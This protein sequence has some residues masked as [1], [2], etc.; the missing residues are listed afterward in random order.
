MENEVLDYVMNT[1][2]NTNPAILEQMLDANSG[3]K[4]PE[5]TPEDNGKVL[6][7]SEGQYALV[8]GGGGGGSVELFVVTYNPDTG[9]IDASYNEIKAAV[10]SGKIVSC[11]SV[12]VTPGL[13]PG[14]PSITEEIE[15]RALQLIYKQT[16]ED[17]GEGETVSYCAAFANIELFSDDPDADMHSN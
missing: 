10:N 15:F 3:T 11:K 14:D 8:S 4:L 9:E 7:V 13:V 12:E 17:S 1:P 16:T 2:G 6:G 5:P